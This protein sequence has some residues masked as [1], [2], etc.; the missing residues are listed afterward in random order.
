MADNCLKTRPLFT[1]YLYAVHVSGTGGGSGHRTSNGWVR[2]WYEYDYSKIYMN[3]SHL[4]LSKSIISTIQKF[5]TKYP[6]KIISNVGWSYDGDGGPYNEERI[7]IAELIEELNHNYMQMG[8]KFCAGTADDC[9]FSAEYIIP[10][11]HSHED[12]R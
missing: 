6:A 5:F 7:D 2:T 1:I 8:V 12:W 4:I 3:V 9:P 10:I 11:Q